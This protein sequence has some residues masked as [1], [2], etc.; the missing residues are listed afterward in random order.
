MFCQIA[1][2]IIE[3]SKYETI[4]RFEVSDK[5]IIPVIRFSTYL[6]IRDSNRLTEIYPE[7]IN[8]SQLLATATNLTEFEKTAAILWLTHKY[9]FLVL[10]KHQFEDFKRIF[11]P[12]PIMNSC[13]IESS[14]GVTECPEPENNLIINSNLVYQSDIFKHFYQNSN[15]SRVQQKLNPFSDKIVV[16]LNNFLILH[17]NTGSKSDPYAISTNV[18]HIEKNS[19]TRISYQSFSVNRLSRSDDKCIPEEDI[20]NYGQQY[21]DD[22]ELDCVQH[23]I[24]KTR[25]C[26]IIFWRYLLIRINK[27]LILS[28]YRLCDSTKE[29]NKTIY[30]MI[31]NKCQDQCHHKCK[32]TEFQMKH[33]VIK[34]S[35]NQNETIVQIIPINSF[36]FEFFETWKMNFDQLIY[37]CGGILGIWFGLSPIK[38]SDIFFD[39]I[40][41]TIDI[42]RKLIRS[43]INFILKM[44]NLIVILTLQLIHKM[45][46]LLRKVIDCIN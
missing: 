8:Y 32:T 24:N 10:K 14:S 34:S 41:A 16:K 39:F 2:V 29:F 30:F 13:H 28:R 23:S 36:H 5:A 12:D 7:V 44:K 3:Y 25:G 46:S 33:S 15:S 43:I 40:T 22:C 17:I 31:K 42:E 9:S 6:Q 35:H 19:T 11:I 38:I 37:I 45:L 4:T 21:F 27:D 18:L 20:Q 26:L 1:T